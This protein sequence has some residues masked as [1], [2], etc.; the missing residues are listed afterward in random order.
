MSSTALRVRK[1]SSEITPFLARLERTTHQDFREMTMD[2]GDVVRRAINSPF[3]VFRGTLSL[4]EHEYRLLEAFFHTV[5]GQ[6]TRHFSFDDPRTGETVYAAF[7]ERPAL[8]KHT[9][10]LR[11]SSPDWTNY[12][13]EILLRDTTDMVNEALKHG[14]V[15]VD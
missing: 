12:E 11:S 9:S 14:V 5:M 10:T 7:M 2:S 13:V 3:P 1:A 4:N 15:S 6:Q 8:K